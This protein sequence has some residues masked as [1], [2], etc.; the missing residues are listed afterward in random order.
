VRNSQNSPN[1]LFYLNKFID[2]VYEE[3]ISTSRKKEKY[4]E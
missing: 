2:S 3:N 4:T 1:I